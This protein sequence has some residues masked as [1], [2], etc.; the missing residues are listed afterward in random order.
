[1]TYLLIET[2]KGINH[3]GGM[4]FFV[5]STVVCE[6]VIDPLQACERK[7]MGRTGKNRR[8]EKPNRSSLRD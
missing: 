5:P 1:M 6:W 8:N 7:E 3:W 2:T 4:M